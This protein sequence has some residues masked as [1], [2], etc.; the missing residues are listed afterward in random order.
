MKNLFLALAFTSIG[1]FSF[2]EFT[3]TINMPNHYVTVMTSCGEQG[4]VFVEE[5]DDIH[6]Y[7]Q[8]VSDLD[9][10]LCKN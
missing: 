2:A 8:K 7:L 3:K 10:Q 9:D 5:D 1:S 6:D 4:E